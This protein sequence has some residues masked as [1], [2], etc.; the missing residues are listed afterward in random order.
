ML[1]ESRACV[2]TNYNGL[3]K[4]MKEN[5]QSKELKKQ[6]VKSIANL[7]PDQL[8]KIYNSK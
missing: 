7:N 3:K 4:S 2:I 1:Q 6:I 5:K 8:K